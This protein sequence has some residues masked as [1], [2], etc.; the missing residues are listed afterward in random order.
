MELFLEVVVFVIALTVLTLVAQPSWG[1]SAWRI[2]LLFAFGIL[3]AL[4]IMDGLA[5]LGCDPLLCTALFAAIVI[6]PIALARKVWPWATGIGTPTAHDPGRT[7]EE[8]P[9]SPAETEEEALLRALA[10]DREELARK[11]RGR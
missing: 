1:V 7:M 9:G 3:S 5:K 8:V 11:E 2:L 4:V 6:G 10:K